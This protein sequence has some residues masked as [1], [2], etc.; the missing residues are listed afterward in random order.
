MLDTSWRFRPKSVAERSLAYIQNSFDIHNLFVELFE[1]RP[2]GESECAKEADWTLPAIVREIRESPQ[3]RLLSKKRQR[4]YDTSV[5]KDFFITNR[6]YNK[7]VYTDRRYNTTKLR[8]WRR[9]ETD[10]WR[11]EAD[12]DLGEIGGRF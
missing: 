3:F 12:R 4:E 11:I 2:A 8:N 6:M 5:L 10:S 7:M 1:E 9:R